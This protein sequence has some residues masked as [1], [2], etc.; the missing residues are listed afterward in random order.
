MADRS[1]APSKHN[2][3][4]EVGNERVHLGEAGGFGNQ[5]T[6]GPKQ[7]H[8]LRQRR[9]QVVHEVQQVEGQHHVER[10]GT[11][12]RRIGVGHRKGQLWRR[13]GGQL[14]AGDGDHARRHVGRVQSPGKRG[15]AQRGGAGAAAQLQHVVSG[16]QQALHPQ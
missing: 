9:V 6:A 4:R 15:Q 3:H 12:V 14:F 10:A 11:H 1:V 16:R 7:L 5:Q 13:L 2:G 8:G